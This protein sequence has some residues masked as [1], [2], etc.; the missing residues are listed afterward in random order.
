MFLNLVSSAPY[1]C[2]CV[3]RERNSSK[4]IWPLLLLSM[5]ATISL[6]V[7]IRPSSPSSINLFLSSFTSMIPLALPSIESKI[8]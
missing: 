4:S 5:T 3:M 2:L 1:I 7:L 8:S 6:T